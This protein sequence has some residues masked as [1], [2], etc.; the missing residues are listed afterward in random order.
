MKYPITPD[1]IG[2]APEPLVELMEQLE[3]DILKYI[4]SQFQRGSANETALEYIRLLQ[5]RGLPLNEIEKRIRKATG[6]TRKQM[7][8]IFDG[9]INRNQAF[10]NDVLTKMKLVFSK[11]RKK[12]LQAEI[13]AL[14]KQ[15]GTEV[16]NITQSLGFAI[17]NADGSITFS[18]IADAYQKVLNKAEV[19]IWSGAFDYNTAIKNA[20]KELTDSGLQTI[21]YASGWHNR[22]DVAARRA[23]MTGI[24][25]ISAKY[26]D[27]LMEELETPYLEVTAH[28]GARDIDGHKGWENHK[29]WQGK[30][31]S[32]HRGDK[33]PD[34]HE[35]CGLGDVAG[36]CGA[37]CRHLYHAFV[38][39]IMEPTYTQE[40]LD[41]LDPPPFEFE[42][43][44]YTM[45][46]AT[47]KQRQL[48]TGIRNIKRRM[49]SFKDAGLDDDYTAAAAKLR[50]LVTKYN[51]FSEAADLKPQFNRTQVQGF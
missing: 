20:V 14:T 33:Y 8:K 17:R 3:E 2:N 39:E 45:Y 5:R 21:D 46:E 16:F 22:V 32:T 19:A 25:Q 26:T 41:D 28:R 36:L 27:T 29:K 1:F 51:D 37:N 15:A 44:Q 6:L 42:G 43:R 12:A 4:C 24:T 40:E 50:A 35:A 47:Q 11:T 10:F 31:Y 34:V 38:P 48:E 18:P 30:I 23:I 13:A 9:A 49:I 7:N